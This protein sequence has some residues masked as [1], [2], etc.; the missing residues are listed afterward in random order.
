MLLNG[1]KTFTLVGTPQYLA[2]E[3]ITCAGHGHAVDCWAFGILLFEMLHGAPPFDDASPMGV[4]KKI[5]AGRLAPTASVRATGKELVQKLLVADPLKRL[6][7]RT[8]R[9][10]AFFRQ[11]N[12][13]RLK[14]KDYPP[15][16][17]P[18]LQS[19]TDTRYFEPPPLG[20]SAALCEEVEGDAAR[21]NDLA[22]FWKENRRLDAEFAHL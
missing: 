19:A 5:L 1:V 17:T 14:C 20:A 12:F 21:V 15:P 16:W 18:D 13:E 9:S 6:G 7:C 8:A 2:P 11:L 3:L 22:G 10:E 4:Y